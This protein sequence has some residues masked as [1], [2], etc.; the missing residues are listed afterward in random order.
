MV[1]DHMMLAFPQLEHR[2][3]DSLWASW[4]DSNHLR[5][6]FLQ[7]SAVS[8]K[9]TVDKQICKLGLSILWAR[10]LILQTGLVL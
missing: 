6:C 4:P 2:L 5:S 3:C 8:S 10:I 9:H 1:T 7:R